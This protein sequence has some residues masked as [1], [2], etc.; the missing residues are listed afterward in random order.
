MHTAGIALMTAPD[1]EYSDRRFTPL[2]L[3]YAGAAGI[4]L[5]SIGLSFLL[6]RL[7]PHANLSLLFL[8]GVLIISARTGLGPSLVASLLSFLAYNFFFTPP[9]Y[10]FE[11]ADEGDVAT[12]IFFLI[13]AAIT[14]N[15]AA[16]MHQAMIKRQLSLQHISDLY[17]FSRR[18]SSAT[19]TED[20][21]NTLVDHFTHTLNAPVAVYLPD[22][23]GM[24]EWRGGAD[25][26]GTLP[27]IDMQQ[28]WS[29]SNEMPVIHEKW[30]LLPLIADQ[31][32]LGI[33]VIDGEPLE[34]EQLKMSRSLCEQAATALHRT[35]LVTDLARTRLQSETEQLRSALLSSVSHDLRT[36]L[37][38][39]IGSTTSLLE[40]GESFSLRI[41]PNS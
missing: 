26:S 27:S 34:S 30:Q 31:K 12:L 29:M 9:Y 37:A 33:M 18:M 16:R 15:L 35:Q 7:M 40:Y 38:S 41:V 39:I 14:G 2:P 8:T 4:V 24:A 11:V 6:H 21:L 17:E 23:Q 36:P 10:T 25:L 32:T 5:I 20:V 13:M 22:N 3:A 1:Q 28:R 19:D